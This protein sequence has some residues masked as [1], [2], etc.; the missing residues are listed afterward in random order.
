MD[1]VRDLSDV[2]SMAWQS[3]DENPRFN[4]GAVL[5]SNDETATPAAW[6][7]LLLPENWAHR[8][9]HDGR[10]ANLVL[11]V[12]PRTAEGAPAPSVSLTKWRQR[13]GQAFKMPHSLAKFLTS[14]LGLATSSE[15]AAEIAIWLTAHGPSLT[16]LVDI[17]G[18]TVIPGSPQAS[19]FMA[20]AVADPAGRNEDDLARTWIGQLS[21]SALHLDGHESA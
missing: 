6:A 1:L 17:E 12:E 14:S 10:Y 8:F 5:A 11:C 20:F 7:R 4:F 16:E 18:A 15:L 19:W 9:G 3:R 21:D 13:F 2:T